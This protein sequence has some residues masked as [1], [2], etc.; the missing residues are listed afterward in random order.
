MSSSSREGSA[1]A[2]SPSI[3]S[4]SNVPSESS[5][6]DTSNI[7]VPANAL[8]G[9]NIHMT[10][11]S[12]LLT[13]YNIPL[14]FAHST[15]FTNISSDEIFTEGSKIVPIVTN[16]V[17]TANVGC[18]LDLDKIAKWAR[19]AEFNKKQFL[20]VVMKIREPKATALIHSNGELVC[21]GTRSENMAIIATR[22]F[23]RIIQQLGFQAR[24]LNFK[25]RNMVGTCGVNFSIR[26]GALAQTHPQFCSYEPET[27]S[28]L[29]YKLVKPEVLVTIFVT[30]KIIITGAK[31]REELR[32]AFDAIYPMLLAFGERWTALVFKSQITYTY[33]MWRHIWDLEWKLSGNFFFIPVLIFAFFQLVHL[34]FVWGQ[35]FFLNS[36]RF[37]D[38]LKILHSSRHLLRLFLWCLF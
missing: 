15:T 30:G 28:G 35:H 4:E 33:N 22:K 25:I 21:L 10:P 19:N 6:S 32:E 12:H 37:I 20:S 38:F 27:F 34:F 8:F 9:S 5:S 3:F 24:F 7:Q 36:I 13:S 26:I 23:A 11:I 18:D 2:K 29:K 1:G 16:V 14:E 17:C 31:S